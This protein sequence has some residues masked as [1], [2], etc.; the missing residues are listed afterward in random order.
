[1]GLCENACIPF[2]AIGFIVQL[3]RSSII[4]ALDRKMS[5][6]ICNI[7]NFGKMSGFFSSSHQHQASKNTA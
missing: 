4:V 6:A 1:L 2:S 7:Q 3:I 5:N